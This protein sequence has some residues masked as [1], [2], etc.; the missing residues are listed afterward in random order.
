M[1]S[2]PFI[3]QSINRVLA[4]TT[5][6]KLKMITGRVVVPERG[7][8]TFMSTIGHLDD[9]FDL[10][11]VWEEKGAAF[12]PQMGNRA[13]MELCIMSSKLAYENPQLIRNIVNR[14]WKVT[15]SNSLLFSKF[16]LYSLLSFN[17]QMHFVDFYD[18]W[19]GNFYKP[20]HYLHSKFI[21]L[22]LLHPFTDFQ[23]QMSTQ[24]FILCDKPRGANFILISFRGTE[25]FDA[26]DWST[27]FDY[28]WCEIPNVGKIHMG[29]LEALGLG[30]R[31]D[32][33]TFYFNLQRKYT[34]LI[35]S[36][37]GVHVGA[38]YSSK[39]NS[40]SLFSGTDS[41]EDNQSFTSETPH[42]KTAYDIVRS[43]LRNLL[44]EHKDA[45]F[46][47]TGHSLGGALAIL[48]PTV[49]VV[50]EEMKIMERLLGV[51][52]FGQPRIGNSQLARFMEPHLDRP[53]PKYF[54]VVY[55]NDIVPR[56]P[57][58]DKTFLYKHFGECLYYN[59]HYIEKVGIFIFL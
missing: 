24:V 3:N 44:E 23:K 53:I 38:N 12:K 56:L 31:D 55:C 58:D 20:F 29:F 15:F 40:E 39:H 34:N 47:V 16:I 45:N 50:H 30:N 28:S 35:N 22:F 43:K 48:F 54:R 14:H 36:T 25:P 5:Y 13:L 51:Y 9:R 4:I 21:L 18:C 49:L 37:N 7:S 33:A 6:H 19:N 26:D 17:L 41:D 32:P 46:I 2:I 59:S 52:T 8:K 27:D 10:K 1:H 57:Y 42:E 11:F